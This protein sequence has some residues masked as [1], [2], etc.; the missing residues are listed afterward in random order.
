MIAAILKSNLGKRILMLVS[1]SMAL[2]LM[3][4]AVSGWLAINQTQ[5][6][7]QQER[8]ALALVISKYLDRTLEQ[9]LEKLENFRFSPGVN[10][11]DNSLDAEKIALHNIYLDSI[12]D[13]GVFFTDQSG[14]VLWFEP[15][16]PDIIGQNY[17]IYTPIKQ[18]LNNGRTAIAK[19]SDITLGQEV[20]FISTPLRNQEGKVV[21]LVGGEIDPSGKAL[22]DV[23]H[24]VGIGEDSY[25]D[26]IDNEGKLIAS[27]DNQRVTAETNHPP[28][29]TVMAQLSYAPWLV[30]IRQSEAT[31]FG[32]LRDMEYRLIIFGLFSVIIVL[33]LSS[34]MTRSIIRPLAQLREAAK[35]ISRGNLSEEI[36]QTSN[37]EIGELSRSFD[38]MRK[39]LKK[40]LEEIQRWSHDLEI[41]VQ[42]RTQELED[43][44]REIE[45]K[46]A[47]RSELIAKLFSAQ[48]DERKRIARELHD[49]TSQSLNGL[50]MRLEA[51]LSLP[52]D[53]A[54]KMKEM[55]QDIKKLTIN[56]IDNVHKIIF[57]LRPS[58]LDDLGLLSAIRWYAANRLNENNIE[59]R[60]EVTGEE[61]KI[62]QKK[63]TAIFRV[64]QEA[65]NN[66]IRHSEAQHAL[67]SLD[68]TDHTLNIEIEDDGKGFVVASFNSNGGVSQGLG[69]LGM[70]ERINLLGG[71]LRVESQP[72]KGTHVSISVPLN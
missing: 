70:R 6:R 46:D 18:S 1:V 22:S 64:M 72:G 35:N 2:M 38:M 65:I 8:Q 24:L 25:I 5:Q 29:V 44:Y 11:D 37:D 13:D 60:V 39:D 17:S 50:V 7:A 61:K 32:P 3:A 57:D 10:L 69:L 53:S 19:V 48:E 4:F 16:Q 20:I 43:S 45:R 47:A 12:F 62:P 9:N 54:P 56:T 26:I 67:L 71:S 42:E 52:G 51:A 59:M 66:I 40:S 28:E 49:E 41:K 36:P 58:L 23:T 31:A 30:A 14:K 33:L 27:S 55:L 21:G 34:G 63:E 68:F 15:Y